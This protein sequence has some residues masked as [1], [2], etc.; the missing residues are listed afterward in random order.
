APYSPPRPAPPANGGWLDAGDLEALD[1]NAPRPR[2]AGTVAPAAAPARPARARRGSALGWIAGTLLGLLILAL[3]AAFA[4]SGWYEGQYAGRIYPG[5]QVLGVDLGGQT[6]A[7][8]HDLLQAKVDAFVKQPVVL[9]WQ[10]QHW[11]PTPDQM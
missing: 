9:V 11:Q 10:D 3:A 2:G 6:Q 8:A 1:A 7:Q 4:I 5:V